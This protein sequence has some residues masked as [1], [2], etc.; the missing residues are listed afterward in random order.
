MRKFFSFLMAVLFAGSMMATEVTLLPSN[1]S[2]ATNAATS[3]TVSGVTAS[4]STG[5][6][7]TDQIRIFKLIRLLFRL[8]QALSPKLYLP[9]QLPVQTSMDLD[10]LQR[11]QAIPTKLM[12]IQ[13]LGPVKQVVFRSLP[14]RTKCAQRKS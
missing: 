14:A 4:I 10:V 1:F 5:S 9:V 6:I 8:K 2:E 13:V 7:T 11:K 12:V 3:A